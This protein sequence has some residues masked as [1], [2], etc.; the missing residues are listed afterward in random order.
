MKVK[1]INTTKASGKQVCFNSD[2]LRHSVHRSGTDENTLSEIIRIVKK[3]LYDNIPTNKI[4][5]LEFGLLK[6]QSRQ[7]AGKYKLKQAIM[8]LGPSGF[9]FEKYI[10]EIL[11]H[12]GY[13][14]IVGE[15]VKGQCVNHEIDVLAEK[16]NQHF[17]IECKFHNMPGT[18]CDVKIPLYIQARFIDVEQQWK[19][20]DGHETKFHLERVVTNTNF[21][22]DSIQYG[23]C[24]GLNLL[25]WGFPDQNS[26]REQ[27][28]E[29]GLYPFTSLTTLT[30]N[31]KQ[32][33]LIKEIVLC[34]ELCDNPELPSIVHIPVER[35]K[36]IMNEA[37]ELCKGVHK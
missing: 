3:N 16:G 19:I 8:E 37:H 36:L 6:K 30:L 17:M 4:Y 28:D 31:E 20:I 26:L 11:K 7:S 25:G 27:I 22:G 23:L 9:P 14:V 34:R 10:A 24:A 32:L 2:K 13:K 15:I 33:L 5:Q 35:R 1:K 21:S 29:S 18:N 12:Q